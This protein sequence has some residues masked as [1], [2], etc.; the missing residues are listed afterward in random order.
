VRPGRS[1]S[2]RRPPMEVAA[3]AP[4][5]LSIEL[6]TAGRVDA[7]VVRSGRYANQQDSD[8]NHPR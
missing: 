8:H 1:C 7:E 4:G 3:E 2:P 6:R 5:Q